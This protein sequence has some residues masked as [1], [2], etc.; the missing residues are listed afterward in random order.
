MVRPVLERR[1]RSI[2]FCGQSERAK[3]QRA[4]RRVADRGASREH[5]RINQRKS[6]DDSPYS[7]AIWARGILH[8]A[9]NVVM[10]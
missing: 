9:P 6:N 3:E 4:N 10:M 5:Q 7:Y 1:R 2:A 8:H